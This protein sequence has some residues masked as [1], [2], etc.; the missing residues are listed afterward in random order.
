[1]RYRYDIFPQG[2]VFLTVSTQPQGAGPR[3]LPR[4][5]VRLVLPEE[6]RQV[7]WSG[8]G[9]G[10]SYQDSFQGQRQGWFHQ[11]VDTLYTPY[12]FPQENGNH[13]ETQWVAV[14]NDRGVG[15]YA[16]ATP[17]L[18]FSALRFDAR[19]LEQ[20]THAHE[21]RPRRSVIWHLDWR[22]QGLGSGSCGPGPLPQHELVVQP[23]TWTV[24]LQPF[25][26]QA[27][28]PAVLDQYCRLE[29]ERFADGV[30]RHPS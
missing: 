10:E 18:E 14:T 26:R 29:L 8:R 6:F 3:V 7:S 12:V 5:G 30:R 4:W 27:I 13:F 25:N 22:Q 21:L 17:A 24:I 9:P 2:Q 20:A 15:L 16:A 19:D 11:L 23:M 1:M 28:A